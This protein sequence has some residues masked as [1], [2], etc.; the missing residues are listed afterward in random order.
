MKFGNRIQ[1]RGTNERMVKEGHGGDSWPTFIILGP[2][3]SIS[4]ERSK[5]ETSNFARILT[6]RSI[7]KSAKLGQKIGEGSSDLLL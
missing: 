5:L 3:P 6:I 2:T 4:L 7:E 1:I